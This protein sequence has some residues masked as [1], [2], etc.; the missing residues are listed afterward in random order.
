MLLQTSG[1]SPWGA[2]WASGGW[3]IYI[4]LVYSNSTDFVGDDGVNYY[5]IFYEADD[6]GVSGNDKWNCRFNM[7]FGYC[8]QTGIL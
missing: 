1:D 2:A 8:F 6:L 7:N 5:C 4:H 3:Y